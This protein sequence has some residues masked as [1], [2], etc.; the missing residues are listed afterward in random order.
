MPTKEKFKI[1]KSMPLPEHAGP[2]ERYPWDKMKV[3]DSFCTEK[4]KGWFAS[5]GN[6]WAKRKGKKARFLQ[7]KVKGKMYC[8]RYK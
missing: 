1:L 5:L 8:W 2:S 7:R 3:G 4:E 6:R